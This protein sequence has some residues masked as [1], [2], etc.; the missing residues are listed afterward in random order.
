MK[1]GLCLRKAADIDSAC[2]NDIARQIGKG[3]LLA[4][5]GLISSADRLISTCVGLEP[6]FFMTYIY[7]YR[8]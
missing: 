1:S 4:E 3:G 8:A 6:A 7:S 5:N 2:K